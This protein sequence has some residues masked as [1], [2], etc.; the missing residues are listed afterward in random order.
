MGL[1]EPTDED[2][3]GVEALLDEFRC[4]VGLNGC[5][6]GRNEFVRLIPKSSRPYGTLY[7]Y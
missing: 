2:W 6:F 7:A 1:E 3:Q 5:E 4:D